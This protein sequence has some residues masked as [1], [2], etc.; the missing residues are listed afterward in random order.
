MD[1]SVAGVTGV[2]VGTLTNSGKDDEIAAAVAFS[3]SGKYVAVC[4]LP[5]KGDSGDHSVVVLFDI[6]TGSKL[7]NGSISLVSAVSSSTSSVSLVWSPHDDVIFAGIGSAIF[8]VAFPQKMLKFVQPLSVGA[9]TVVHGLAVS[10]GDGLSLAAACRDGTVKLFDART[11]AAK[12]LLKN[13]AGQRVLG[14]DSLPAE[15]TCVQFSPN[16]SCIYVGSSNGHLY[17][18]PLL[19]Q[20]QQHHQ[21]GADSSSVAY[22]V[23]DE[24]ISCLAIAPIA[25][26]LTFPLQQQQQQSSSS[27]T[28]PLLLVTGSDDERA[29]FVQLGG[30]DG[31][32]IAATKCKSRD[33]EAVVAVRFVPAIAES[34]VSGNNNFAPS[35]G[36]GSYRGAAQQRH[37]QAAMFSAPTLVS[38]DCSGALRFFQLNRS[39]AAAAAAAVSLGVINLKRN[40]ASDNNSSRNRE[41]ISSSSPP[42]PGATARVRSLSVSPDGHTACVACGDAVSVVHFARGSLIVSVESPG[43][44][45]SALSFSDGGTVVN[46][47]ADG[48]SQLIDL[49]AISGGATATATSMRGVAGGGARFESADGM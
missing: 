6:S 19:R 10:P 21:P 24:R 30:S 16:G 39:A 42:A 22:E 25:S 44:I 41:G 1:R 9:T 29:A 48:K 38:L 5:T 23:H 32:G 36:M 47:R 45:E 15:A 27:S 35:A 43:R 20:Q 49:R 8:G 7:D 12:G 3:T 37:Q 18:H 17:S 13:A 14:G 34:A 2:Q 46:W 33:S 11:G 28:V 40:V 26:S 31:G 4:F